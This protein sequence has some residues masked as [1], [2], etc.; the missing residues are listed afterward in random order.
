MRGVK[1]K[2][3]LQQGIVR[4]QQDYQA[5]GC[6]GKKAGLSGLRDGQVWFFSQHSMLDNAVKVHR[7]GAVDCRTQP[8][9]RL[10]F[11]YAKLK[12]VDNCGGSNK[13][14]C[15]AALL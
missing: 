3:L 2:S 12:S 11:H 9:T 5:S 6:Q 7:I 14:V 10:L 4:A 1:E 15:S 13:R 8:S